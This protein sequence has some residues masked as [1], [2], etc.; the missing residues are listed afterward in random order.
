MI[1]G[2]KFVQNK[3]LQNGNVQQSV[4]NLSDSIIHEKN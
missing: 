3:K 4:L 2:E 1:F